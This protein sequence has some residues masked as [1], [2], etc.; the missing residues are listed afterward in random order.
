MLGQSAATIYLPKLRELPTSRCDLPHRDI[1]SARNY[2]FS[3][4][5]DRLQGLAFSCMGWRSEPTGV[6]R[7]FGAPRFGPLG[8]TSRPVH[9]LCSLA[10]ARGRT[11][12]ALLAMFVGSGSLVAQTS[13]S[14]RIPDFPAPELC[15]RARLD[16]V[17][18]TYFVLLD[19]SGSMRPIWAQVKSAVETFVRAVPDGDELDIRLFSGTVRRLNAPVP[20]SPAIVTTWVRQVS[21]LPAPSGTHTDLGVAMESAL[22]AIAAAPPSRQ[23]FVYILTDGAQDPGPGSAF[24]A[25]GGGKWAALQQEAKALGATR[26][27]S[28]AIVRL[29]EQADAQHLL[30]DALPNPDIVPAITADQL[31]S[32]FSREA[33]NIAVR[34]LRLLIAGERRSPAL[35]DSSDMPI[36]L[37]TASSAQRSQL[38]RTTDA[39]LVEAPVLRLD[40][41]ATLMLGVATGQDV[42]VESTAPNR[43]WYWP[44]ASSTGRVTRTVP[45][46]VRFAPAAE[47]GRIGIDA[48]P[49]ADSMRVSI[50]ITTGGVLSVIRYWATVLALLILV[51]FLLLK[52]KWATHTALITGRIRIEREGIPDELVEIGQMRTASYPLVSPSGRALGTLEAVNRRG[53]TALWIEP[54]ADVV[55]LGPSQLM[56]RTRIHAP[57]RLAHPEVVIH[58][59]PN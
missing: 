38:R 29:N 10:L 49:Q 13:A 9:S 55:R 45:V 18:A 27:V 2:C 43:P 41:G 25:A 33:R 14:C 52:A 7:P 40:D 23:Q 48:G 57:I 6:R 17:R 31:R 32:W 11:V 15:A 37:G 21:S 12:I 35:L 53:R 26:P 19:E 56:R 44:P 1:I 5:A 46:S 3:E 30:A 51:V 4:R 59:F 39:A 58:Y 54:G 24:P 28:F 20:A 47:L 42:R 8:L 34:K 50:P 22:D 36:N 16:T